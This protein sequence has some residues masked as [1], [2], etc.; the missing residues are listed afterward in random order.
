PC[1]LFVTWP[2]PKP[3]SKIG[4]IVQS[5]GRHFAATVICIGILCGVDAAPVHAR[6][7]AHRAFLTSGDASAATSELGAGRAPARLI[8]STRQLRVDGPNSAIAASGS[9]VAAAAR[10]GLAVWTRSDTV[11]SRTIRREGDRGPPRHLLF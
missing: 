9:L 3:S 11:L 4:N 5:P 6:L 1:R 10:H 7:V 8:A 2:I